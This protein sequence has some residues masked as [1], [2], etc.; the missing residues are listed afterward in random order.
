MAKDPYPSEA[1]DRYIVRFP[2]GM[3]DRLKKKAEENR[4]SLNAEIV[5]RLAWS[6]E[7]AADT[8]RLELTDELWNALEADASANDLTIY[9]HA[10]QIL[11]SAVGNQSERASQFRQAQ[12]VASEKENILEEYKLLA[13]Q[14]HDLLRAVCIQIAMFREHMPGEVRLLAEQ[15]LGNELDPPL[16]ELEFPD[17]LAAYY[18]EAV[19]EA[20]GTGARIRESREGRRKNAILILWSEFETSLK[21]MAYVKT[22]RF[23]HS[24]DEALSDLVK[25][26]S[27][28]NAIVE[29]FIQAKDLR[30]KI[31]HDP[32]VNRKD[33]TL[34]VQYVSLLDEIKSSFEDAD[35]SKASE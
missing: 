30:D 28:D 16:E 7:T 31:V 29:R 33:V 27:A 22:G 21:Q 12:R 15:L 25:L 4:R 1:A 9:E 8:L 24:V 5:Q 14:R 17:F 13:K 23:R 2:D 20:A 26:R 18:R 10:V 3:R 6:F 11:Q 32:A 35:P 34:P 19:R